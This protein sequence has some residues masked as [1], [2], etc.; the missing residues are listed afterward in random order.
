MSRRQW[1]ASVAASVGVL[2]TVALWAGEPEQTVELP[3][4]QQRWFRQLAFADTDSDVVWSILG[5]KFGRVDNTLTPLW[6]TDT[7]VFTRIMHTQAGGF[8]LQNLEVVFYT[9]L[10]SGEH[11]S[12]WR[13]VYRGRD[14]QV[15]LPAPRPVTTYYSQVGVRQGHGS[16]NVSIAERF[17][18]TTVIGDSVS[19]RLEKRIEVA[20]NDFDSRGFN[21]TEFLSYYGRLSEFNESEQASVAATL[22]LEIFSDWL[23]W[24]DMGGTRG[25]LYTRAGGSKLNALNELPKSTRQLLAEHYP[26]IAEDPFSVFES[27]IIE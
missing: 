5:T 23:P 11:L 20:P 19:L 18:P 1:L 17:L 24:M 21:G 9:D 22:T 4:D 6:H 3:S 13:N 14:V 8:W 10:Q 16:G 12:T 25:G 27:P 26:D 2:P 15:F 7:A